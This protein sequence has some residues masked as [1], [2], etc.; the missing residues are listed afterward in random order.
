MLEVLSIIEKKGCRLVIVRY[1]RA[2]RVYGMHFSTY[3][4]DSCAFVPGLPKLWV[5]IGGEECAL[6]SR[7]DAGQIYRG[8][9]GPERRD[10]IGPRH[11]GLLRVWFDGREKLLTCGNVG[12]RELRRGMKVIKESH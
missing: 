7:N 4:T 12:S 6:Q 2:K 11:A 3:S 1:E 10:W 9:F 5:G 8:D